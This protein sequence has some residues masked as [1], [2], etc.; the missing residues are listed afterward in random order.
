AGHDQFNS[1][2][3]KLTAKWKDIKP[4]LTGEILHFAHADNSDTED[5][6]TTNYLRDIAEQ[7]GITTDVLL[8]DQIGW[9]ADQA[10]FVDLAERRIDGIF[11][12]YPWEW[13]LAE[14]FGQNVLASYGQTQWIEP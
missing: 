5:L 13:I 10:S 4:Y 14:Q 12:L 8:M 3:E 2:H 9:N 1:I 6:I 7:A 11:K